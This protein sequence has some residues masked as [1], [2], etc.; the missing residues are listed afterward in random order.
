[1]VGK[2]RVVVGHGLRGNVVR[3]A[4]GGATWQSVATGV[5]V[6]LTA[7]TVDER[8]ASSL[9]L[10]NTIIG[11]G[12]ATAPSSAVFVRATVSGVETLTRGAVEMVVTAGKKRI[13]TQRVSLDDVVVER[14]KPVVVP[15]LLHGT[16]CDSIA[17][18]VTV[19][20]GKRSVSP[21]AVAA[22]RP[23]P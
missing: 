13:A 23:S 15:F 6:G 17:V 18:R 2:G 14:G 9:A 4:D 16:G 12:D 11:E 3:S 5:G 1:M 22:R 21:R 19:L 7:G 8:E 20:A 10:W